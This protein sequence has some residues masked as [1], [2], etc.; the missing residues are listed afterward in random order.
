MPVRSQ[1]DNG[2]SG[3]AALAKRMLATLSTIEYLGAPPALSGRLLSKIKDER[4]SASDI[5]ELILCSPTITASLL[6]VC[7]SVYYNRG[8]PIDSV[9]RA[10]VHLGLDSVVRFVYAME[11]MGF[12]RGGKEA[13]GFQEAMFWKS[14]LAGAL[15][16]QEI[17]GKEQGADVESVFLGGLLRDIGVCVIR[18]Y[19]PDL[20]EEI[21][22]TV[23]K[24][25]TSFDGACTA[26]CGIDHRSIAFLLAVR[27]NLP[28][29]VKSVFQPPA[30]GW[31]RYPRMLLERSV[32]LYS[33]FL[34]K[35]RNTFVW[36]ENA[37]VSEASAGTFFIPADVIDGYM[38]GIV[39]DVNELFQALG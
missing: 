16:A 31:E 28:P 9:P 25:R 34:L 19:F 7:N 33:D 10:I 30:P 12:F 26:V 4:S 24:N 32:V 15:L 29:A 22:L 21:W 38:T 27:W 5:A 36:D 20:F 2:S 35:T 13:R 3:N 18:Q 8:T 39:A 17:A 37:C 1:T 14:G 11:M 6:K 23:V